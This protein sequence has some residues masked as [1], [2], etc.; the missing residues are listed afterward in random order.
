[1]QHTKYLQ[2]RLLRDNRNLID[3]EL[4]SMLKHATTTT[5]IADRLRYIFE[6]YGCS[7]FGYQLIRHLHTKH[8][9]S[10]PEEEFHL[11]FGQT[12]CA[13]NLSSP[14]QASMDDKR[15][16]AKILADLAK[17][18]TYASIDS[19]YATDLFETVLISNRFLEKDGQQR[20]ITKWDA[21]DISRMLSIPLPEAEILVAKTF[22][23]GSLSVLNARNLIEKSSFVAELSKEKR[24]A[25][26]SEYEITTKN[27]RRVTYTDRKAGV[28]DKTGSIFSDLF[29]NKDTL[30]T[31]IGFAK[32]YE[33]LIKEAPRLK[34]CSNTARIIFEQLLTFAVKVSS[35]DYY[36]EDTAEETVFH[37]L[38][39]FVNQA[40]SDF[41]E[42]GGD[43]HPLSME[44]R[45]ALMQNLFVES[46]AGNLKEAYFSWSVP[47]WTGEGIKKD[48]MGSRVEAVLTGKKAVRKEDILI[49]LFIVCSRFWE[50]KSFSVKTAETARS[51]LTNRLKCFINAA[52]MYLKQAYLEKFY[53]PHPTEAVI[54]YA[55]LAGESA[56]DLYRDSIERL[57]ENDAIIHYSTTNPSRFG[58]PEPIRTECVTVS[59]FDPNQQ[60]MFG[61]LD[62]KI[63]RFLYRCVYAHPDNDLLIQIKAVARN[64]YRV[65]AAERFMGVDIY[66]SERREEEIVIGE[67][68]FIPAINIGRSY[69]RI[70]DTP[71]D[72]YKI[73]IGKEKIGLL[74]RETRIPQKW[75]IELKKEEL[76]IPK[77]IEDSYPEIKK[78][79]EKLQQQIH[80]R[81]LLVLLQR[82]IITLL[83]L[84][85]SQETVERPDRI[86]DC[87]KEITKSVADSTFWE[88]EEEMEADEE[89]R[90]TEFPFPVKISVGEH[91][92]FKIPTLDNVTFRIDK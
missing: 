33:K 7:Y 32:F 19:T 18:N 21:Y 46:T 58:I 87:E 50:N 1:M 86:D 38:K 24:D 15:R 11:I 57:E 85:P 14:S 61:K 70:D 76:Y 37:D 49:A 59:D 4:R 91:I 65:F 73:L 88:T 68:G 48:A 22:T 62:G 16:Y 2:T 55:I 5:M 53:L 43:Y 28:T 66:F 72:F 26:I 42:K 81:A 40:L 51:T 45:R 3:L 13:H 80:A 35:P 90:E 84:S 34:G 74:F 23:D 63:R 36:P 82:E 44:A 89:R 12:F 64:I 77:T 79:D 92:I 31:E 60:D 30:K 10:M 47:V 9:D 6:E 17:E 83:G 8:T 78:L 69:V 41:S 27:K 29:Q 39:K 75:R 25:L 20:P 56:G 71:G 67:Y 54:T 52:N